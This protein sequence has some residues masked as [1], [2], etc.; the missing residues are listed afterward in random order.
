METEIRFRTSPK[1]TYGSGVSLLL[2]KLCMVWSVFFGKHGKQRLDANNNL[3][4]ISVTAPNK[5]GYPTLILMI[6]YILNSSIELVYAAL[7]K[8]GEGGNQNPKL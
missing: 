6:C 7:W 1:K 3:H 4:G 2:R 5:D 8:V